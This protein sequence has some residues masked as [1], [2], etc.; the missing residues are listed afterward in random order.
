M[1]LELQQLAN[2]FMFGIGGGFGWAVAQWLLGLI[3][4]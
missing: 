3:A 4:K 2:G 1:K